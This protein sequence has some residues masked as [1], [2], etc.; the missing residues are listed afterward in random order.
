MDTILG[1]G[2]FE[3][4]C[5]ELAALSVRLN[6]TSCD[7]HVPEVE[8]YIHTLKERVRA[9]CI[10]LLFKKYPRWLIVEMVTPKISG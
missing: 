7:E 9:C 10:M 1:D 4:L 6:T 5:G 2:Q 3:P 8:R